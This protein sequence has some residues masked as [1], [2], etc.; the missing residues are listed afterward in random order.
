MKKKTFVV[1]DGNSVIHRAFHA[2]PP[3]KNKKG[4]IVNAVYGFLLVLIKIINE[5]NPQYLGV[6][7]DLPEPTFRKK[8]FAEYKAKRKKAPQELYDQIPMIKDF[9]RLFNISI[10]EKSG[11]EGD[12]IIGTLSHCFDDINNIIVSGDLDTLQ[13]V[14]KNTKV[15]F[16]SKGVK[17]GSFYDE[18]MVKKRYDGLDKEKLIEYK[19]LRGDISDNIP[20]VKGIGEKTAIELIKN[21]KTIESLYNNINSPKI[22]ESIRKKLLE[23]KENAFLSKELSE[24]KK[25][26]PLD[27]CL[28]NYE[29][30]NYDLKKLKKIL[31]EYGFKSLIKRIPGLE[32]S[33]ENLKLW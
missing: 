7:F 32:D 2:L 10:C 18:D 19:A 13:L 16:L 12:D 26:V 6:C 15:Y 29:W 9:L 20:G 21:F 1:I 25:D 11:F 22:T 33:G 3:L 30:G 28:C 17:E 24:I 8:A 4:E 31:E 23:G 27:F 5:F 14:N